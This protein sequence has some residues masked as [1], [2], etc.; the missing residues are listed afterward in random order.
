MVINKTAKVL[1][2]GAL[3]MLGNTAAY[4]ENQAL[5]DTLLQNGSI[6]PAQYEHL[7]KQKGAGNSAVQDQGLNEVLLQNRVINQ[8]QYDQLTQQTVVE[9]KQESVKKGDDLIFTLDSKGFQAKTR[10]KEFAFKMGGRIQVE[11]NGDIGDEGLSKHST[12][13]VEMRRARLYMKGVVW[14]DYKYIIEVDFADNGVSMKDV[15]LTYKGLDWLDITIGHQKQPISMELQ[16]SSN[17]IM[18]AER[19]TV[20]ALTGP[21]FDRAIGLHFKS[22]SKNWSAQLG[23]YGDSLAPEKDGTVDE[24]WSVAS[25]LTYAPINTKNQ[26]LHL[27]AF[28]GYKGFSASQRIVKFFTETTHMSNLKLT[29]IRVGDVSGVGI[30][31]AEA[32]Y[33]FGSFSVQGEYAHEWVA[34]LNGEKN[35][36]LNAAYVQFGWT[37]TGESRKYKGSDGEFKYLTPDSD[38]N[39]SWQRGTWGV[40]ELATRYGILDAAYG[41]YTDGTREQD[42]TV[43]LNWYLNSNVRLMA[44]YRYAFDLAGSRVTNLNGSNLDH[45]IHSFTFRTQFRL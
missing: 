17:D 43:A 30:M 13:G 45:G 14:K 34:R 42:V 4:A 33:M 28:G 12:E 19:S 11:A 16:E 37:L 32:A 23:F 40:F 8:T 20:N 21:V 41:S 9:T 5:L 25:R 22:S 38:A 1:A 24:G 2:L 39:F 26:V 10:D 36:D 6:T 29:N 27:G 18:F 3:L 35:L 31:G 15:F 7:I 44:D